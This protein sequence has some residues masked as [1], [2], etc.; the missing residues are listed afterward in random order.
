MGCILKVGFLYLFVPELGTLEFIH[1]SCLLEGVL[2]IKKKKKRG[3]CIP[4]DSALAICSQR[5]K[6]ISDTQGALSTEEWEG[7]GSLPQM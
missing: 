4:P 1:V 7:E 5:T 2:V 3:R 6:L